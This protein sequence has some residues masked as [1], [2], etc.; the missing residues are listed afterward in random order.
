MPADPSAI[1]S[2][3]VILKGTSRAVIPEGSPVTSVPREARHVP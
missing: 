1:L 3:A 2:R